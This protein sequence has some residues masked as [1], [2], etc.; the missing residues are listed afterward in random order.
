MQ[1]SN[2]QN[3]VQTCALLDSKSSALPTWL[4][5]IKRTPKELNPQPFGS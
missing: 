1:D 3:R 2:S 4:S 5:E